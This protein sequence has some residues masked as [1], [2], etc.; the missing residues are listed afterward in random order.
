GGLGDAAE[1]DLSIPVEVE[2]MPLD[3]GD[4]DMVVDEIEGDVVGA[5]LALDDSIGDFA[6]DEN[7]KTSLGA[8]Q[9]VDAL[10]EAE[11]DAAFDA[12]TGVGNDP[13]LAA[14][15]AVEAAP[16]PEQPAPPAPL[17]EPILAVE[18]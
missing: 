10:I 5:E 12:L 2:D 17:D 1:A 9:M 3:L 18:E 11:T 15:S 13:S 8:P 14:A 7:N 6:D 4:D 16:A